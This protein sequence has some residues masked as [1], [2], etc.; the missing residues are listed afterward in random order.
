MGDDMKR[1]RE[2]SPG[3]VSSTSRA[4]FAAAA[5]V[6]LAAILAIL[7]VIAWR[8]LRVHHTGYVH[9]GPMQEG[10]AL[11]VS[12][13]IE[14]VMPE[15][16]RMVATGPDGGG[17][18]LELDVLTCPGCDSTMIPVRWNLW[19]GEIDWLCPDCGRTHVSAPETP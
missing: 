8:G 19:T 14:L 5:L 1:K 6:L 10:I 4:I 15:A 17:V 9:L 12:E 16:V 11:R 3:L 13:P 7:A 18:P 2:S